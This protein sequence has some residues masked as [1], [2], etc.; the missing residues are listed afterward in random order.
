MDRSVP[1]ATIGRVSRRSWTEV[2]ARDRRRSPT[3]AG[4]TN[5]TRS[6]PQGLARSQLLFQAFEALNLLEGESRRVVAGAEAFVPVDGPP[7]TL[8]EGEAW[9]PAET[10]PRLRGVDLQEPRFVRM[11]AGIALPARAV[12][13][14]PAQSIDDPCDRPRFIGRRAEVPG[15]T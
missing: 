14:E 6:W 1:V 5:D 9:C 4:R 8:F 15:F 3:T 7:Q 13:P 2:T 11:R 12:A 10:G